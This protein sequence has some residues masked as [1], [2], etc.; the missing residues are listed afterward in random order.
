M[1]LFCYVAKANQQINLLGKLVK[2]QS[3][4]II[5]IGVYIS[6]MCSCVLS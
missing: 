4:N 6:F 5:T 3:V 1:V 2:K